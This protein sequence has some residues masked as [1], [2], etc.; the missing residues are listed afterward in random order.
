MEEM[1]SLHW[2]EETRRWSGLCKYDDPDRIAEC[3]QNVEQT[4]KKK[5]NDE[6]LSIFR[7]KHPSNQELQRRTHVYK[8]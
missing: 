7:I 8:L 1:V 5:L 6:M 4:K 3:V 2:N